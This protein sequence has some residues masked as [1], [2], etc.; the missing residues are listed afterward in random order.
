[1][2][3]HNWQAILL[4]LILLVF[5][6]FINGDDYENEKEENEQYCEMVRA[7]MR[8]KNT[9]WPDFNENFKELCEKEQ[10]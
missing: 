1:M 8:D 7:Y 4:V 3:H 10:K 5:V 2:F 9:G 6:F